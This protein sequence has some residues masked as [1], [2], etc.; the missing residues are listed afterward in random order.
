MVGESRRVEEKGTFAEVVIEFKGQNSDDLTK[1]SNRPDKLSPV[2]QCW[3][4]LFNHPAAKWGI[5]T[6][7]NEIRIYNKEKGQNVYETFYFNVPA[8][9]K[10]IV[11]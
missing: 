9:F 4:Y 8:E 7:F 10:P 2:D 3:K 6:N 1:K 11:L 5:V